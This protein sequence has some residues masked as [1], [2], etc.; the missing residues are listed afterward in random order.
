MTPERFQLVEALFHEALELPLPGRAAF[1]DERCG[2]DR[3]LRAE[4]ES[5]LAEDSQAENT[6]ANAVF[7]A[8]AD[9][10][11]AEAEAE[12]G[13]MI[14]NYRVIRE[15]G[16]GGM[17]AV[18]QAVRADDQYLQAVAIK[19]LPRGVESA[20][21]RSRFLAERQILATLQHPNIAA[22]LDGG[23]TP[24][25]RPYLVME[26]IEGEPV[27][28]H[29]RNRS[30]G[31]KERLELFRN[32]CGAVHSAHQKLVIHRDI[33]PANVLV[34]A[35]GV[36]K[37]LDFGIA[38]LLAPELI[39]GEMPRTMTE[40]RLMTP[41][42]ASPE[43]VRGDVLTT[44][45][46]IY[47]LGVLLYEL[48]TEARAYKVT[49][50]SLRA[51]EAA[52]L[53]QDP[54]PPS[55]AA[56]TPKLRRQIAGDLDRIV[57][58]A[59]HK[60]T[61]RRYQSA[62]QLAED[63]GRYL[64]GETVSARPDTLLYRTTKL[65]RR[66]PLA[67][68]A[69]ALLVL[70]LG[71][72]LAAT[73][74]QARR[75]ERRFAQVRKLAN[76]FLFDFHD[77]IQHL[78]GSTEARA[79]VVKTGLEY[80]DSLAGEAAGDASLKAELAEAYFRVAN[81]QGNP[82]A[83][84]LGQVQQATESYRKAIRLA[85]EL[86]EAAPAPGNLRVLSEAYAALG[87]IES[88]QGQFAE[89]LAHMRKSAAISERA[90]GGSA[91]VE[92]QLW[93]ASSHTRLGD[94]LTDD[95]PREARR[96]FEAAAAVIEKLLEQNPQRLVKMR[97]VQIWD[98]IGRAAHAV[99][100]PKTAVAQYRKAIQLVE[101]LQRENPDDARIRRQV[102]VLHG[103]LG[104]YLGDPD[105][106]HLGDRAEAERELQLSYELAR[107]MVDRDAK[108]AL[109][110]FD[111]ALSH[112]RLAAFHEKSQPERA[113]REANACAGILQRVLAR[114]PR[115]FRAERGLVNCLGYQGRALVRLGRA[116]EA[117]APAEEEARITAR[118]EAAS[119][120]DLGAI[121][122]S[123]SSLHRT[124]TVLA[125]LRQWDRAE[126]KCQA[127]LAAAEKQTAARPDDLYFLRDVADVNATLARIALGRGDR[128]AARTRFQKSLDA[129]TRFGRI[130]TTT[131]VHRE[132][133]AELQKELAAIPAR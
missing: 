77:K 9:Y 15:I 38:K 74:Y 110:E 109:A 40:V 91:K 25:G 43:Q 35:E 32:V 69:L 78:Q 41:E 72:G 57:A 129:W 80:L 90:V 63:I 83:A 103:M 119:P 89:G 87:D 65:V 34:T 44:S 106:F 11:A 54:P 108:D 68:G 120:K 107:E 105:Y 58:K 117:L 131:V 26:F 64:R 97:A 115:N 33:K 128:A 114:E 121:E 100:D 24:D 36:P 19:V 81:V 4:V 113:L 127:S 52:V 60:D 18:F 112:V 118:L 39:P 30:L 79:F 8:A 16:R 85:E 59:M 70:S 132:A 133:M 31:I 101:Q 3:E 53:E 37:L 104:S 48:L 23:A 10:Q 50:Q 62:E 73:M 7:S 20:F 13:R 82:R 42:Y 126:A 1:L 98:R 92:D 14:G 95:A 123:L 96:E 22:L 111:L 27:T 130:A 122:G 2:A 67:F 99:G 55:A 102:E 88:A 84:N 5:L 66:N 56:T 94:V 17:G 75:A 45:T 46:D 6:I 86:D 47:S 124:C 49:G 21:L 28:A 125:E 61:A 116:A 51:V 76:S 29:C 93:L 71:A 12:S